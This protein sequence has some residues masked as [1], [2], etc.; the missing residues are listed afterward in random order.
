MAQAST[1]E[2]YRAR[3]KCWVRT[4]S[5]GLIATAP[6]SLLC[7]TCGLSPCVSHDCPKSVTHT[8]CMSGREANPLAS[9]AYSPAPQA[10]RGCAATWCKQVAVMRTLPTW[11]SRWIAPHWCTCATPRAMYLRCAWRLQ[12]ASRPWGLAAVQ[13]AFQTLPKYLYYD[14]DKIR[15]KEV[16]AHRN[17]IEV[18]LDSH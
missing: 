9:G 10:S 1:G 12:A 11:K 15:R 18:P 3:P 5:G 17:D 14:D 6:L 2:P 13:C 4:H 7:C 16:I 8:R